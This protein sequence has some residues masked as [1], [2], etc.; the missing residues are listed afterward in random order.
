MRFIAVAYTRLVLLVSLHL[1]L[2]SLFLLQAPDALHHGRYGPEGQ[3]ASLAVTCTSGIAG[4]N[5]PCAVFARMRGSFFWSPVHRHRAG[6]H[7]HRD[8]A[9]PIIRCRTVVA[10]R[11]RHVIFIAS[12]PP[13]PPRAQP[14]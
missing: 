4:D 2:F 3:F 5:A 14:G 9:P 6:G 11:Q 1:A 10:Y 13:P 12:G 7:V 8:M